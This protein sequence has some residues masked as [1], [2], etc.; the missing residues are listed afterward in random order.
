ML[1]TNKSLKNRMCAYIKLFQA[2]TAGCKHFQVGLGA[3]KSWPKQSSK[4]S[5]GTISTRNFWAE[6]ISESA[7]LVASRIGATIRSA[8]IKH[9]RLISAGSGRRMMN[10]VFEFNKF[11]LWKTGKTLSQRRFFDKNANLSIHK[12]KMQL[13]RSSG[14]R[15]AIGATK[16]RRNVCHKLEGLSIFFTL[17]QR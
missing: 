9:R 12:K 10:L 1:V 14:A 11:N 17:K 15:T 2:W 8:L 4:P 5:W 16:G 13:A 6:E 7:P 3:C